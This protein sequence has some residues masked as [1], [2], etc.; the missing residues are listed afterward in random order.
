[1]SER[2]GGVAAVRKAPGYVLKRVK[3]WLVHHRVAAYF[4]H[5]PNHRALDRQLAAAHVHTADQ[6]LFLCWGNICRSPM[7]ERYLRSRLATRGVDHPTVRS[8]GLGNYEG[9]ESP[10]AARRA[11]TRYGVTLDDHRSTLTTAALVDDS[12]AVFVMDYN[13]YWNAVTSYPDASDRVF[14]LGAFFDGDE[15]II[16]DPHGRGPDRFE[17]AYRRIADATEDL[18]DAIVNPLPYPDDA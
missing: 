16:P 17:T 8:A 11:A 6:L 12:D 5:H 13:N 4:R 10:P 1:M 7:A 9:R 14:F 3:R 15:P 18:V 2:T